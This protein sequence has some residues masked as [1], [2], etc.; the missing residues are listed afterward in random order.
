MPGNC[1]T[2]TVRSSGPK[3]PAKKGRAVSAPSSEEM[4]RI[5]S[6]QGRLRPPL[7]F[8]KSHREADR[9]DSRRGQSSHRQSKG[10]QSAMNA[11]PGRLRA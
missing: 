8:S 10:A 6:D 11:H 4:H 1:A 2:T 3:P 9:S 7:R 5:D